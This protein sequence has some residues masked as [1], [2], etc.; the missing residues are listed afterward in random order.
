[1]EQHR[2]AVIGSGYVGTTVAVCFAHIG[3]QVVGVEVDHHKL[4]SLRSGRAP[5]HEPEVDDLLASGL[6]EGRLRFTDS[7]LDAVSCSD[8]VFL[9]VG[10]PMGP[11]GRPDMRALDAAARA[12]GGVIGDQVVVNKSTIPVGGAHWLASI[13][14]DGRPMHAK[15]RPVPLVSNPEFLREGT[16]VRDFLHPTRI[17]LGSD[18]DGAV[19]LVA[20]VYRPVLERAFPG[21]QGGPRPTLI[22]TTPQTAEVIKFASNAFLATKVSFINEMANICERVGADVGGVA[23][24]MGL[25][26]RIGAHFLR[27]GI[28]WGGSCLAKDLSE[29][30]ATAEQSDYQPD[31]LKATLSVNRRQRGLV[32][33]KLHERL[34]VLQGRRVCLLGLAFK[35]GT[36]DVRDAPGVEVARQ[37]LAKGTL[38]TAHDPAVVRLPE[39]PDLGLAA[40]AYQAADQADATILVTDWPE[41]LALDFSDLRNRMRG[42]LFID[43]RNALDP[44]MMASAGFRYECIGGWGGLFVELTD[45]PFDSPAVPQEDSAVA[46]CSG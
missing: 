46:S 44:V 34:R 19:D 27:A 40:D 39:L 16:A 31:L 1:M 18:D 3:H 11:D 29:L 8:V 28:G 24:A 33:K 37:L 17:V 5:F 32:V 35:P 10:A 22:R 43:G 15:S 12:I 38:V 20:D 21:A 42:D 9:C 7:T 13:V 2:V 41:F 30:I 26:P 45:D 4:R 6:E 36:D 14:A 25:D 23:S